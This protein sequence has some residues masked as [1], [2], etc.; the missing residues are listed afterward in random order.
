MEDHELV[1]ELER[2]M[3]YT[4]RDKSLGV[5]ALTHR[6]WV[7]DFGK[8]GDK[9]SETLEFLGDA[10]I[11][12]AVGTMLMVHFP[13]ATEGELTKKR[14]FL[15]NK[16]SLAARAEGVGLGP[17]IRMGRGE[18][19]SGGET[20]PSILSDAFE[21]VFGAIFLDSGYDHCATLL[22]PLFEDCARIDE[23]Y[24]S[25]EL[26]GDYKSALQEVTQAV[27]K[28]LP[29]YKLK[30]VSGPEHIQEFVFE[31]FVGERFLA[32]G[33]GRSKK[34]AQQSAARE[35]LRLLRQKQPLPD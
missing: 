19:L 4:F 35:G 24:S 9:H 26:L 25:S 28:M 8:P 11:D 1:A 5:Q 3:T 18:Q 2:C 23:T 27:F 30:E 34:S 29:T 6:S 16:N 31:V 15:V 7:G 10:V 14:A 22:A 13:E 12:L 21:A 32:S 20:K 33:Q 17:L